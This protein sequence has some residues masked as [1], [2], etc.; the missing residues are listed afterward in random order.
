MRGDL[1]QCLAMIESN[2]LV[3]MPRPVLSNMA[4]PSALSRAGLHYTLGKVLSWNQDWT[5]AL[6]SSASSSRLDPQ[7]SA[8]TVALEQAQSPSPLRR[9][10]K[11]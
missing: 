10:R 4:S 6:I 2:L 9:V 7:N 5:S 11:R 8:A 3:T 1:Y